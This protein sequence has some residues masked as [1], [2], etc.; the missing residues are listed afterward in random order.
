MP[1]K[2][3]LQVTH[4]RHRR[5]LTLEQRLARRER[6]RARYYAVGGR[7]ERR[8]AIRS[9]ARLRQYEEEGASREEAIQAEQNRSASLAAKR[10]RSKVTADKMSPRERCIERIRK[11]IAR[12][13]VRSLTPQDILKGKKLHEA[14][15]RRQRGKKDD[16]DDE[17]A[18]SDGHA[19]D[20]EDGNGPLNNKS[21][22]VVDRP[23]YV[24]TMAERDLRIDLTRE[25]MALELGTFAKFG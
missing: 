24:E 8:A 16:D 7:R 14:E 18:A 3:R 23:S 20:D 5:P 17:T 19:R 25:A 6:E 15:M 21:K 13:I 1:R 10:K 2:K 11:S 12:R 9:A 4:R 22:K